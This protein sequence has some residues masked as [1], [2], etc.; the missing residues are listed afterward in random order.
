MGLVCEQDRDVVAIDLDAGGVFGGDGGGV[1][2]SAFEHGGEAEEVAVAGLGEDDFLTV[3]VDEGDVDCAGEDDVGAARWARR[4]C[5]CA[6]LAANSRSS[7]C[8]ARTAELVVVE[9]R[10]E[11]DLAEF[12]GVAGHK[13][14]G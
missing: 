8:W 4:P 1:V 3:F 9:K 11:R 7:T 6:G 13:G 14:S 12:V 5:R 2:G 10:E